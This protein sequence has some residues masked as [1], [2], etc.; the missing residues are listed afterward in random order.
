MG[1]NSSEKTVEKQLEECKESGKELKAEIEELRNTKEKKTCVTNTLIAF[2][3]TTLVI[4]TLTVICVFCFSDLSI[5][6]PYHNPYLFL[7]GGVIAVSLTVLLI[8]ICNLLVK[9]WVRKEEE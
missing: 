2:G 6:Y 4:L 9:I 5:H 3:V 1:N 7:F 8:F